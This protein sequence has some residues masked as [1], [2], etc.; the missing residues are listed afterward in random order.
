MRRSVTCGLLL[1]LAWAL[2][3]TAHAVGDPDVAALQ[4]GLKN[5][6]FYGGN[7]D[8]AM[9]AGTDAALRRFQARTGL[10]P[11]GLV[12]VKTRLALGRYGRQ[13][14]LGRRIL[15]G[16]DSGWDVAALQF[17]LA[18]QGFPSGALDGRLGGQTDSA[19]RKFQRWAGITPDGRAG[20]AT[21]AALRAEPPRSPVALTAPSPLA[22]SEGFGPRGNRF[23]TGVDY[24]APAG[25]PALA[26]GVGRVVHSGPMPGGWGRVVVLDH[27]QGLRTWYAH[28][29]ATR[30]RVGESVAAGAAVGLVGASGRATG[31]HLHFEVQLRGA[32]LDPLS[33]LA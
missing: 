24:P 22:P 10:A 6:G 31:P 12:G 32:A 29:S 15:R 9:G 21:V 28:L 18:W 19:L 16:G 4:V 25:T 20:A 7:V 30:V 33:V 26:A 2:P 8:G 14:P 17:L 11:S 27:G 23:H 3:A 5:R 1:A 13:A